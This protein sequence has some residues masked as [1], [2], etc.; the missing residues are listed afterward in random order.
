MVIDPMQ[1]F[2]GDQP[3][4][5]LAAREGEWALLAI[6]DAVDS[7]W[8][9]MPWPSIVAEEQAIWHVRRAA[10]LARMLVKIAEEASTLA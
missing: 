9:D 4:R 7:D 10:H 2:V 3:W 6:A 8:I 1:P 5:D